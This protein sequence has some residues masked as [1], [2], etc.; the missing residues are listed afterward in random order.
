M[1]LIM[2]NLRLS[3]SSKGNAPVTAGEGRARL[4]RAVTFPREIEFRL[5]GVSPYNARLTHEGVKPGNLNMDLMKKKIET[6]D[7]KTAAP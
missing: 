1:M 7:C 4:R 3:I 5:D 2:N 6:A